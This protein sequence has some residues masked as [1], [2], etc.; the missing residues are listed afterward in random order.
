MLGLLVATTFLSA[1]K[2][3]KGPA[4]PAGAAGNANVTSLTFQTLEA[5]WSG[6][7]AAG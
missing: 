4:G 7:G 2:K 6:S 5:D 1:C 3:E